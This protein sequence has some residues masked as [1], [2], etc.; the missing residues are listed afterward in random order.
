M[1]IIVVVVKIS[2]IKSSF[3]AITCNIVRL[4]WNGGRVSVYLWKEPFPVF[5]ILLNKKVSTT[6][7]CFINN[8][9]IENALYHSLKQLVNLIFSVTIIASFYKVVSLLYESTDRVA[10][11][12]WPKEVGN[13]LEIFS[14]GPDL[15]YHI[16]GT[17][18][19]VFT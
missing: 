9:N 19:I 16:F 13:L 15:M 5:G 7:Y 8:D 4:E 12:E 1:F 2:E 3:S 14:H 11:F 18:H 10:Q 17:N 6:V